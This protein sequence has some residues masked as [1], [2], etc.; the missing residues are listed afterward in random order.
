MN[1]SINPALISNIVS[2][3]EEAKEMVA[4]LRASSLL[5]GGRDR[6][7]RAEEAASKFRAEDAQLRAVI[8]PRV[9]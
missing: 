8:Q 4:S 9:E 7:F 2:R 3:E 6:K 5:G 1:C